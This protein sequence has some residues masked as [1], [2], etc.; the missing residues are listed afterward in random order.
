M[1]PDAVLEFRAIIRGYGVQRYGRGAYATVHHEEVVRLF[2][3]L[4]NVRLAR[5]EATVHAYTLG[6]RLP[7]G[8]LGCTESGSWLTARVAGRFGTLLDPVPVRATYALPW[9]IRPRDILVWGAGPVEAGESLS[10]AQNLYPIR[11]SGTRCD[12]L[13]PAAGAEHGGRLVG[14]KGGNY[15]VEFVD[16]GTRRWFGVTSP[17][18]TLI[19]RPRPGFGAEVDIHAAR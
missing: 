16:H 1:K 3:H 13:R 14:D 9:H 12:G 11:S 15:M 5:A 2:S 17:G 18:R 19:F 7:D 4:G 8:M 10:A 6:L